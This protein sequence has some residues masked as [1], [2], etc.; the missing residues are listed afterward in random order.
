MT[1]TTS[2]APENATEDSCTLCTV[3]LPSTVDASALEGARWTRDGDSWTTHISG[4]SYVMEPV[5]SSSPCYVVDGAAMLP[6]KSQFVVRI[7]VGENTRAA[8]GEVETEREAPKKKKKKK[9]KD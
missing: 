7:V 2:A 1:A 3:Q 9:S 4:T 6:V 8:R 5:T